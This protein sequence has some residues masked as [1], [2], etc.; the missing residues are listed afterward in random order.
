MQNIRDTFPEHINPFIGGLGNRENDAI[1]YM[2][3]GIPSDRI[4]IIDTESDLQ[5]MDNPNHTLSYKEILKD[6]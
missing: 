1:A 4:Y 2:H 5:K 3:A 6:I